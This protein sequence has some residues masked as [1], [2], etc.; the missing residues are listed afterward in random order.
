MKYLSILLFL[1]FL[2]PAQS[3]K[4]NYVGNID[5]DEKQDRKDFILCDEAHIFQYFN[6]SKGLQYEGEKIAIEKEFQQKY[7]S[8]NV[9]K[10]NAWVRIRFIVNCFGRSDRFRILTANYDYEPIEIDKNITAQLLE[11]TKNLDGWI[12]KQER[13]QK[14]DYYQYLT[15]K[16]KNGK[17]DE[18]LP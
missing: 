17:I 18:I 7:N 8:K 3:Q 2:F 13:G 11:I 10:E 4:W 6:D 16:I 1:S 15:F 9:K 5:F 12:P 14:I